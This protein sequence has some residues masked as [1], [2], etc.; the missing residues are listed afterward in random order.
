M[1][2]LAFLLT[3]SLCAAPAFGQ[4]A[5]DPLSKGTRGFYNSVK[6]NI[7][8]S[9]EEMPEENYSFKPTPDVRSFGQLIGH[10]ADS[11]YEFCGPVNA[12]GAKSPDIEKNK[13]S[14]ADLIQGLKD[15]FA[16]CDKAYDNLTDAK[17]VEPASFFRQ[18]MPKLVVLE[19]N[20][21]HSDEHYG[22]I[23][24]YLRMKG[25]VPPSSQGQ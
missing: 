24:T 3:L 4:T 1:K 14:K 5:S 25:L 10:V 20:I 11:Q 22:N 16:Y 9:A 15:A 19:I 6:N 2:K 13:T 17:A 12:D 8:K 21:A 18:K 23:V 7:L